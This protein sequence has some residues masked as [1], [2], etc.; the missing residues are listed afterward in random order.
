MGQLRKIELDIDLSSNTKV[1]QLSDEVLS[2]LK[3]NKIMFRSL[4]SRRTGSNT[5]LDLT[6]PPEALRSFVDQFLSEDTPGQAY[7]LLYEL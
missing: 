5:R 7:A 2:Y 4:E 1:R 3:K 6:G